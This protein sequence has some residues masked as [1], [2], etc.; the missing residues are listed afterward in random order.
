MA[1]P[2]KI[3]YHISKTFVQQHREL[4]FIYGKDHYGN[5]MFGQMWVFDK[6]PN[7]Y[8]V[9]TI[10]RYCPSNK[11]YL[12]DNLREHK[13]WIDQCVDAIPIDGRPVIVCHGIGLGCSRMQELA[14]RLYQYMCDRLSLIQAEVEWIQ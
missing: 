9:F 6:E 14:P 13:T 3:P 10:Q 11:R 8:P 12:V 7:C 5:G 4:I 2:I 1:T